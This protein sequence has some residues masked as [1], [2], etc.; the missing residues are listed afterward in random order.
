MI[1]DKFYLVRN[2]SWVNTSNASKLVMSSNPT[3]QRFIAPQILSQVGVLSKR[4]LGASFNLQSGKRYLNR[5][6]T[7]ENIFTTIQRDYDAFSSVG[8]LL[9]CKKELIKKGGNAVAEH[10]SLNPGGTGLNHIRRWA[11]LN[12]SK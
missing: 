1:F 10:T 3:L 8:L 12:I 9:K 11:F 2:P 4:F 6:L 5:T 7:R